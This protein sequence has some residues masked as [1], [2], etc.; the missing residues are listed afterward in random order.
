M[1]TT[2][3]AGAPAA[4]GLYTRYA[5][6][7]LTLVALINFL[8]RQIIAILAEPIKRDLNLTDSEVG[9]TAGL[10]FA[11]MYTTLSIPVAWLADR[12]HRPRIIATAIAVWSAMTILCGMA[13]TFTQLFLA[14][15]GVGV[16]EAG[17]GPATHSLIAD[18]FPPETRAGA[19]GWYAIGIPLGAFLA[20]AAG[21]WVVDHFSWREAFM[22]A[23]V[24]GLIV[25]LIV[26]F[27]LKEPR[28]STAH[29]APEPGALGPALREL[30]RKPTYW[31]LCAAA[32]LV[33][34]VAYGFAAFYAAFFVR[35]HGM[36]YGQLGLSLG[37]VVGLAGA[38]GAWSGGQLADRFRTRSVAA[39]LL[40]P[41][42]AIV[43]CA[44]LFA[45]ALYVPDKWVALALVAAPTFAATFYYGP[46]FATVQG[47]ARPQ[48]RAMAVAVFIFISSLIGMGVGPVF[49]GWMSDQFSDAAVREAVGQ[50]FAEACGAAVRAD[51]CASAE[52]SGLRLSILILSLFNLWAAVHFMLAAR[53][54]KRD[55]LT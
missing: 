4:S 15:V 39:T 11:L 26:A 55:L 8:D 13:Q 36:S 6:G 42:S 40:V 53:T 50:G 10:S 52:A 14:R 37:L 21:G 22:L 12:W 47:L 27:T 28:R 17:S 16:G 3:A 20:Y 35:I 43:I 25:A 23:G 38:L 48:T 46:T 7:V 44:P 24:P 45:G 19:F 33:A 2:A 18:Y 32:T 30:A 31:H 49:A 1:T 9:L 5:L 54:I 34:F 41:A 51:I 29:T